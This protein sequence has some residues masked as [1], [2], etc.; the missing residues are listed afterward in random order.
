MDVE[1]DWERD[2]LVNNRTAG[3]D[4]LIYENFL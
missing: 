1:V 3:A 4:T 2:I